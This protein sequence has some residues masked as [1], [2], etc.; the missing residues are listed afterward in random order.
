MGIII[1]PTSYVVVGINWTDT[2]EVEPCL[3]C[4]KNLVHINCL[5]LLLALN[6]L[7]RT[8]SHSNSTPHKNP[9][10]CKHN[11][12]TSLMLLERLDLT[13]D[14]RPHWGSPNAVV[15][16]LSC[17]ISH[18]LS[19]ILEHLKNMD[20]HLYC[21]RGESQRGQNIGSWHHTRSP[22]WFIFYHGL[23]SD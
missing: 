10:K 2:C 6:G 22:H 4:D 15:L 9:V 23:M 20:I 1:P 8:F 13:S 16:L 18:V 19:I 12:F 7:Q 14:Q 11:I 5:L 17:L 3:T 21:Y